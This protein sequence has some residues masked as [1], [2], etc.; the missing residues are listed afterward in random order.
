MKKIT[1]FLITIIVLRVSL[2]GLALNFEK[3]NHDCSDYEGYTLALTIVSDTYIVGHVDSTW[4]DKLVVAP[5][6]FTNEM[7]IDG[8][9]NI[10]LDG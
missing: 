6:V 9:I 10:F 4:D 5:V 7:G 2:Y 1:F 3:A 8:P